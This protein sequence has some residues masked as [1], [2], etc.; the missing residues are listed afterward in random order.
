MTRIRFWIVL[1]ASVIMFFS[2]VKKENV[3]LNIHEDVSEMLTRFAPVEITTDISFLAENEKQAL[4]KIVEASHYMDEIFLRQAWQKN[5]KYKR[6]LAARKDKLGKDAAAYFDISIGL[7]DRLDEHEKPFINSL[8]KPLGAGFYPED[9]TKEEFEAYVGSNQT[10]AESLKG[11]F[12]VVQRQGAAL[13][14]VDYSVVYE[15]WLTPAAALLQDAAKLTENKSLRNFLNLRANAFYSNDYHESDMAWMDLDSPVEVTIGPY[16]V[17]ED[18]LFGFKAAFE[19]FVTVTNPEESRKLAKFKNELPAMEKNLPIPEKMKNMN[20]GSESPIRVVDVVFTAG[21][22]KS[23]VQTIAYNL[24]NDEVVR[25]QKGSKKV[26]LK[27]V[28]AAKYDKILTPIAE[29]LIADEQQQYLSANAFTN[30]VLFHELSHGLGP[31]KITING[32]ATEVRLELKELYSAIEES[33]ADIMGV[34]N[35]HYML[36]KK[37]FDESFR[38]EI[39][40]TYLA[41]LFRG[42]RFGIGEA[43]GKGNALQLNYMLEKGAI[44]YDSATGKFAVNFKSFENWVRELVQDI[45]ILQATGDYAGTKALFDKY[46]VLTEIISGSLSKLNDIPVDLKPEYPLAAQLAPSK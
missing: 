30:E 19:S 5:P 36:D 40:V 43:H 18:K 24:P 46:V 4:A 31:G 13:V 6:A 34:Y 22:T 21:D 45:C 39:A 33:K 2:C 42:I 44:T 16:E 8:S 20:R 41:G 7:W 11:L 14:A 9:L 12:T 27:N 32:R 3:E 35:I 15:K 26:L 17:Y 1:T 29:T 23:G 38:K 37:L 28:I 10:Q 25:E